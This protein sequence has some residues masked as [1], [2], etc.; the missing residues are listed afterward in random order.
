MG[1][2]L[3]I[4]L[5]AVPSVGTLLS[6]AASCCGAA[7]CSAVCSA[8]GNCQNSILTRIAYA[9]ILLANSLLSWLML[10]DWAVK[11]LQHVL[12]DYVS[13]NCAGN[14]CFGFAAVHR[15]N[16]ALG[17]FHFILAV[18]LLGVNNSRDKRAPIQNGFWGPKIIAWVALIV[19]T[20]LIPNRFFEVW[21]NYVALIGAVL[22]L[23]LGLVLLVDLAHTF[24]EYCIEKIEDTDSGLWRG[25]LI[26]STLGMYLGSIA[27]TVVMYI[28]FAH[29]GCS[30]NQA[31]ITVNLILLLAISIISIHPAVQASNPRAGLAQAATV[32]IYCTYLTFSAVAMEPDDQHCNPLVRATGTRTASVIIGAI[33]T[34]VT[35]AYTTTRAATY[36]LALGTGKPAGYSPVDTEEDS[37]GLVDTQPESRRAMRQEALRRAV[38]EG[39]LPASALDED[40]EDEDDPRTGVHKNDDEKNGTQYNYALFHVIFMLATAWVATLLTQNIGGDKNIEKGDFV[41]VGRTY[42]ASW[43]KIVSSWVCYG[44]FGWTLGAPVLMPDRFDYS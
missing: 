15:V 33:V 6:F 32:S 22:F 11:R 24:A 19:V 31:A 27:M 17:L 1:A 7:T 8:C 40:D 28:F 35:C 34:F 39:V 41:P 21:G 29:S 20:F 9:L 25:I 4:P 13:I 3:S 5:L 38:Q 18:L 37:H 12:L 30:M 2:L 43:V 42:W 14:A 44:I 23:L 26:G 16:F 36:G 10:T